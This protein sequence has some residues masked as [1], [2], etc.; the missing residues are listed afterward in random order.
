MDYLTSPALLGG[1][2][3]CVALGAWTLGRWQGGIALAQPRYSAPLPP[4]PVLAAALSPTSG[5]AATAKPCQNAAR[6]DRHS[7]LEQTVS[8]CDLHAEISAYRQQERIFASLADDAFRLDH[9]QISARSECRYIGLTGQPT[10][11]APVAA[12]SACGCGEA[13][14]VKAEAAMR[15][16]VA[17][18]PS[19]DLAS[20]TR[21]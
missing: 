12:M 4:H 3:I 6:V 21:V 16:E 8:L 13:W 18:Y 9:P 7:V 19:P 1:I 17:A 2:L 5:T 20:F 15:S 11:G 10:C 14:C